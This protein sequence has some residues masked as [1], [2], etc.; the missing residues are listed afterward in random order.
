[1]RYSVLSYLRD[2]NEDYVY[3]T[4]RRILTYGADSDDLENLVERLAEHEN[5]LFNR[6]ASE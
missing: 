5:P 4:I 1:M 3:A 6:P 2:M